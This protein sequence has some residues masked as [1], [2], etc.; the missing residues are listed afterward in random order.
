VRCRGCHNICHERWEKLSRSVS[1][2]VRPV[3]VT[4]SKV[5]LVPANVADYLCSTAGCEI[6][7]KVGTGVRK[8]DCQAFLECQCDDVMTTTLIYIVLINRP[9]SF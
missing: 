2:D 3:T 8:I 7:S 4:N 1:L 6:G 9:R 5:Y